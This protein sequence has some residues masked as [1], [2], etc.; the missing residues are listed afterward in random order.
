MANIHRLKFNT[1][2]E[3]EGSAPGGD[4]DGVSDGLGNVR[5]RLPE[6]TMFPPRD[7]TQTWIYHERQ[8]SLLCGQ[9][10]LNNFVQS[11]VFSADQLADIAQSLDAEERMLYLD[12]RQSSHEERGKYLSEASGNVDES[13]NFSLEVLRRALSQTH[14]LELT[15]ISGEA[16]KSMNPMNEEVGFIVNRSSH[17]FTIR[18]IRGRWWNLNSTL[19][20]PEAISDLFLSAFL[21]QLSGKGWQVFVACG[22]KSGLAKSSGA[23]PNDWYD[24]R[25]WYTEAE[26]S[27][28]A[29]SSA[30]AKPAPFSG[31]GMKLG[32]DAVSSPS[33]DASEALVMQMLAEDEGDPE[34]AEALRLS[35]QEAVKPAP[36]DKDAMRAKR[37]AALG[38]GRG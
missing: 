35:M 36:L 8:E 26:L 15:A 23:V 17:W 6:R 27:S 33:D 4:V 11:S 16:A 21:S 29:S 38:A 31:K 24:P 37:L 1:D 30:P 22:D 3:E 2:D 14:R 28:P 13:G 5:A 20:R 19:G 25:L 18:K 7:P 12:A 9:H 32:G 34:L 10:C